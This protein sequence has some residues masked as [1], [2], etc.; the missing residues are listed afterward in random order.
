MLIHIDRYLA[1]L[2]DIGQY[3][4]ILSN[5]T[6]IDR[7]CQTLSVKSNILISTQFCL[8]WS[9]IARLQD[10]FKYVYNAFEYC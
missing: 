5:T 2:T 7:Y 9:G 3:Y 10:V 1:I 8:S 4:Q 6:D